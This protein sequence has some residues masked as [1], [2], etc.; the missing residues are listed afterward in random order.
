V[1]EAEAEAE[2]V[3]EAAAEGNLLTL[4]PK[5]QKR[6]PLQL[7]RLHLRQLRQQPDRSLRQTFSRK[8]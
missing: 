4:Q 8:M 6:S 1:A 3:G 5:L 7:P 2:A